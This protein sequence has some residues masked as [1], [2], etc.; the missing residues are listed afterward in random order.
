MTNCLK[1]FACKLLWFETLADQSRNELSLT[2]FQ[3]SVRKICVRLTAQKYPMFGQGGVIELGL[4]LCGSRVQLTSKCQTGAVDWQP[5]AEVHLLKSHSLRHGSVALTRVKMS[6]GTSIQGRGWAPQV[7]WMLSD[8]IFWLHW[9]G[10]TDLD[11]LFWSYNGVVQ[12]CF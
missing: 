7:K 5:G 11:K 10:C 9:S 6:K 2:W 3:F 12:Q 8:S 4:F 1:L